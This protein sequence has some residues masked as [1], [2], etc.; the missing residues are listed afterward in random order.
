MT[1]AEARS[2]VV[3]A[4]AWCIDVNMIVNHWPPEETVAR[5]LTQ[6]RQGGCSS[7]NMATALRRLGATFPVEAIGLV[8]DDAE[9]RQLAAKCD[10]LDI[11]RQQLEMRPGKSTSVTYAMISKLTGKRTFFYSAG[12]HALQTP[13]DFDFSRSK[14][15]IAH[16]GMPGVHDIMDAP[17]KDDV[18]GWV[19]VLSQARA[20][21]FKTN[22]ELVS[23]DPAR[24]RELVEPLLP[25][26]D[27]LIINDLEAGAV[28]GISTVR[29][30]V[31]DITACRRTADALLERSAMSLVAI[32]FPGGAILRTRDGRTF[33]HP[34]VNVPPS[35]VVSTNG[36]GDSFAAGLLYGIHEDWPLG[37][38][39]KL[40]H[41]CAA[42]SLRSAE[43]TGSVVHWQECLKFAD[44]W[45]WR[46]M[47]DE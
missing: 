20:A 27:M 45:G 23:I 7:H 37:R 30:G 14:A 1:A 10:E 47:P 19:T 31:T 18:S 29:D 6:S 35:V 26:L 22:I 13:D 9:G 39:V 5:I 17:W 32:H 25:Y 12:T 43:T 46:S 28:A 15:R 38:A 40:A 4:G 33:D 24:I 41:A 36:A 3:C 2:G 16:L 44:G 34:S 42:T 21:G 8:G 11:N